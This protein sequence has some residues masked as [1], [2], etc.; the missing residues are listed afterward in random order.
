M[1]TGGVVLTDSKASELL[2]G[3]PLPSDFGF[4]CLEQAEAATDR[5]MAREY[6]R[7]ARDHGVPLDTLL[8][9]TRDHEILRDEMRKVLVCPIPPN[10]FDDSE[11]GR[12][13][14]NEIEERHREF[15]EL[16]RS[17]VD[18]LQE[19]R[20]PVGL[21]HEL[22]RAYF[23]LSS[24]AEGPD[25]RARISDLCDRDEHLIDATLA[26][27]G[28]TP[29]R[30]DLPETRNIVGKVKCRETYLVALPYLAGIDELDDLRVLSERQFRQA[31]AFH[32]CS[33]VE[34]MR[35]R[36]ARLL[37][38]DHD[39]AAKMLVRC[40]GARMRNGE[41][42]AGVAHHLATDE[43]AS[44]ARR[45]VL[46]LLRAFPVRCSKTVP[47][48]MLD[49]L[50]VTALRRADRPALVE[51]I[52]KKRSRASMGVSQRVHWLAAEVVATGGN[53]T[54]RL[55]EFVNCREHRVAQL[56]GFLFVADSLLAD[57]PA[58]TLACFIRVLAPSTRRLGGTAPHLVGTEYKAYRSVERMIDALANHG[59]D[60]QAVENL[61]RL[62]IDPALGE[63]RYPLATARDRQHV[64]RRD[65]AYRHPTVVAVCQTL[66]DG[67][68]ADAGDLAALLTDRFLELARRIRAGNTDDWRQYWNEPRGKEP[69]P[70]HEDHSRDALLSD[71]RQR[72]PAGV[73]AQP[74]GQ[75][76]N[77]KRADIR[78]AFQ[79]F[80]VPVEIKKNRHQD[81]WSAARN[82]LVAKYTSAPTTSGY[83]IY[84]VF[85][86]GEDEMPPPPTGAP[87]SGPGELQQRL[88]AIL[89]DAERRK[90]SVVV[91]DVSRP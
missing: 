91:I 21:L 7:H 47:L 62:A 55:R 17:N 9:R 69:T 85:W 11:V 2:F 82:Q 8:N 38:L 1:S 32:F 12:G 41:Y 81:L 40:I 83:G 13:F 54:D 4:W 29:F 48:I 24:D 15:I 26:G 64:I 71:L 18:A 49:D 57:L 56:A 31:L 46:P 23:G 22:A 68:P 79:D 39:A 87:P 60:G 78:V 25:P 66:N 52:I 36:E 53:S 77:D 80:E 65:A 33:S 34:D 51:L 16:V 42:D 89:S 86:L 74:E 45:A 72:L 10:Y 88:E 30:E 76:A 63:W 19:N 35:N 90:I 43:Y 20:C 73:D 28:R 84:L 61:D 59:T 75:Y 27:L 44:V 67:S 6:L 3:S 70:K 58:S 37:T 5:R 50:L 14:L